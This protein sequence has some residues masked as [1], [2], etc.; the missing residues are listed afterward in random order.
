MS[1]IQLNVKWAS[2]WQSVALLQQPLCK[3]G[4][5]AFRDFFPLPKMCI[6]RLDTIDNLQ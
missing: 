3:V 6:V 5:R 1:I 4:L 2:E